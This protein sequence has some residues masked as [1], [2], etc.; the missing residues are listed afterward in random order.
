MSTIAENVVEP[1]APVKF[2]FTCFQD[3]L[4]TWVLKNVG[5]YQGMRDPS[6]FS[7]TSGFQ[8]IST[9]R[10]ASR[11]W[12]LRRLVG[13]SSREFVRNL[14]T[15]GINM[16]RYTPKEQLDFLRMCEG[17]FGSDFSEEIAVQP[18]FV[19][20]EQ[21]PVEEKVTVAEPSADPGTVVVSKC[22][23]VYFDKS[24]EQRSSEPLVPIQQKESFVGVPMHR[25]KLNC[26]AVESAR[27]KHCLNEQHMEMQ[28]LF[29]TRVRPFLNI[30]DEEQLRRRELINLLWSTPGRLDC[31]LGFQSS[32]VRTVEREKGRMLKDAR[33]NFRVPADKQMDYIWSIVAG[34]W[35]IGNVSGAYVRYL[36]LCLG[37]G[38]RGYGEGVAL[39]SWPE[40]PVADAKILRNQAF[41]W[42]IWAFDSGGEHEEGRFYLQHLSC[43]FAPF[44]FFI[45][46]LSEAV[47]CGGTYG[48]DGHFGFYVTKVKRQPWYTDDD[49]LDW[50]SGY[51]PEHN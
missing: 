17:V 10:Y 50:E 35:G 12:M 36:L 9:T 2:T 40:F 42:P 29:N 22:A 32:G 25:S 24:G 20:I 6:A 16:S 7:G 3:G 21:A 14:A 48:F 51:Q 11:F 47:M 26:S 18:T 41:K 1:G 5:F 19:W 8:N 4:R 34:E 39:R 28:K 15:Y 45:R 13:L 31:E 43:D 49:F 33:T 44:A 37:Y 30:T 46:I 23:P 38:H 27:L